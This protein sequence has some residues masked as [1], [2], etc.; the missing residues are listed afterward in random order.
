MATPFKKHTVRYATPDGQRCSPD[1]PGAVKRV[2][3]SRK[4]YGLVPLPNGK[5]KAVPLCPDLARS[6]QMLNKLLTDAAMRQHGLADPYE[7]HRKRP[8]ADHLDDFAAAL[9]AKGDCAQHVQKTVAHL[10]S[11][12]DATGAIWLADLDAG[13][14]AGWLTSLRADRE[15]PELP[16]GQE[17]F[18][19][20]ELARML[21]IRRMSI[22]KAIRRHGLAAVG[23]GPARRYPRAT[24]LALLERASRG[25]SPQ[26]ANHNAQAL[27]SFGRW[28]AGKRLPANPFDRL[29]L[30]N[31]ATDR[32]HDRRELTADELRRLLAV[33]G[34][35][36]R[37]FRGLN[38]SDRA[39]LYLMACGTG[40]RARALAGLT[41]NDFD[42]DADVP[43][44]VLPARL[45]KNKRQKVQPLP[46]DVAATLRGYLAGRP[47]A[48]P[49]WPGAWRSV[50][51]EM[52]RA[53]LETAGIPYAVEGADGPLFADFHSL[54]HSYLTLGGRAGIDLRTLQ[55]LAGHST[56]TLTARY[57]HR[58]L[59][60]LAGA[61]E[62][63]PS[64]LP[65]SASGAAEPV[66]LAAT[67]TDR[68]VQ[69]PVGPAVKIRPTH[70]NPG[71]TLRE[72]QIGPA[73]P[74]GYAE[75]ETRASDFHSVPGKDDLRADG[76][77]VGCTLVAQT[78]CN[79]KHLTAPAGT[80]GEKEEVAQEQHNPLTVQ[81]VAST[82]ISR[83]QVTRPGF[84]PGQREPKSLVLP[85]HY[86]VG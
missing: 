73:G 47:R 16:H 58:R 27:R 23:A 61:V 3:E 35:S 81:R 43:A 72:T 48:L 42:L 18:T 19:M 13:K 60:D 71:K 17:L 6:K 62:K 44:V 69:G 31:T 11:F 78:P 41:P 80:V 49:V 54:R 63:L 4:Y 82:G 29:P 1:T 65:A 32:R 30:L 25:A 36:E 46:A 86:R 28:L 66:R 64:L 12:F 9:Q 7:E 45:A 2:E 33:T 56:P 68:P 85:L 51:A 39:A 52:L 77:G 55:E 22:T 74:V 79:Q 57:S 5:R 76:A 24:V 50:A 40:F 20:A 75:G 21:G 10:R 8:L 38:G 70:E 83:H 26:T 53:D 59:H 14:A 15:L 37:V 84:E 67:G 34:A